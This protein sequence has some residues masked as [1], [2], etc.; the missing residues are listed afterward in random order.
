MFTSCLFDI[1][2]VNSESLRMPYYYFYH[3]CYSLIL[4]CN[5]CTIFLLTNTLATFQQSHRFLIGIQ[6]DLQALYN[7]PLEG[8]DDHFIGSS[9][10]QYYYISKATTTN[11][12]PTEKALKIIQ[13]HFLC[14]IV[15][16]PHVIVGRIRINMCNYLMR[17][18]RLLN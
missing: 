8:A 10:Y 2:A 9:W 17:Y 16:N 14:C 12:D 13:Y 7:R 4:C 1:L 18:V 3:F 11:Q 6:D 15:S 5:Y